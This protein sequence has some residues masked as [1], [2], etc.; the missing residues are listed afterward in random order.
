M[1]VILKNYECIEFFEIPL[2]CVAVGYTE[3]FIDQEAINN[4]QTN[5]AVH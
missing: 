3:H 4:E 2:P 1:F 5:N